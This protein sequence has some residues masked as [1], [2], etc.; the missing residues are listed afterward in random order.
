MTSRRVLHVLATDDRRG[1]EVFACALAAELE[2]LGCSS[3]VV[4]VSASGSPTA[5]P[6]A[7]IVAGSSWRA[8]RS[9]R[10]IAADHDVVIA[11]G[12]TALPA[13]AAACAGATPFVYRSIG[14][15]V[16]WS[17]R[18]VKRVLTTWLLNRAGTVVVLFP[19]AAEV[20]RR[21]GVRAEIV[22]IPNAVPAT[23]FP[24]ITTESR[25]TA[26]EELGLAKHATVI[27]YLGALSP[28]KGPERAIALGRLRHDWT[29]LVV[30]DG[31]LRPGLQRCVERSPNVLL[32][33][34]TSTPG[35][36]LHAADVVVVPSDTEGVPAVAIEAGLSGL[37]VV[38]SDVGGL[39]SVIEHGRTGLLVPRG[40][41]GALA[42]AVELALRNRDE[43]GRA[44][45]S[46]CLEC[47]D[48]GPVAA[49]WVDVIDRAVRP[50][51]VRRQT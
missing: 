39:G 18:P 21:R 15:P 12:S 11:H 26:R 42:E 44:A 6:V 34:P 36:T 14:D 35:R 10:R 22:T 50:P 16:Y 24:A 27:L 30:G 43:I 40:D 25:M 2:P 4:A 46:R 23:D 31:P 29:V 19:E 37:P 38:A 51:R 48:I 9:L 41:I 33:G 17:A 5:V 45:R 49:Q 47:F 13:C 3:T 7:P 8:V 28:E 1:A 20:L 32:H